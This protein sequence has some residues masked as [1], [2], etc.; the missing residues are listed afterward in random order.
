MYEAA[1]T[2]Y[3]SDRQHNRENLRKVKHVQKQEIS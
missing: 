3:N 2:A 1:H